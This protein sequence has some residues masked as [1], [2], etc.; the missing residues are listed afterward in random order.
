VSLASS[1]IHPTAVVDPRAVLGEDVE[2][3]A[4]AVVEGPV[5][6]GRG[7]VLRPHAVVM[8][9]TRLGEGNVVHPGAVLGAPP[10]DLKYDGE[11]TRIVI[12]DRNHFRE[13]VTVHPGTGR[14]G[15]LT[16]IGSGNL[17]MVGS[18]VAHDGVVGDS[19]VLA[20]HVLLAGHVRI[21]DR[22]V[23][24]GASALHHFT[25]VG[26][27]AYVGGLTRITQDVHPF[28]IVEGHPARV[29]GANVV[30]MQRAG[31]AADDVEVIRDAV[32]AIFVSEK[33]N[34]ADAMAR[35]EKEHPKI[36][37]LRELLESIRAASKGRQGRAAEPVRGSR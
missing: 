36:A 24:N 10:Q 17:L 18:H 22:A 4:Y 32:F 20:N 33:E 12:G 31:F 16:R 15:G 37:V 29:R 28:T 5:H 35:L 11:R 23:L 9:D 30:G 21:G 13:H 14:G 6:L 7:T 3:G 27:L 19:V 8:G 1:K 2:I 26:R 34:S 25:T